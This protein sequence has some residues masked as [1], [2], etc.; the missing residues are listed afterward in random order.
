M[1]YFSLKLPFMLRHSW[2]IR[3]FHFAKADVGDSSQIYD[4]TF[5]IYEAKL[6]KFRQNCQNMRK[7]VQV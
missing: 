4:K 1:L 3:F 6:S 2:G 7:I 5:H